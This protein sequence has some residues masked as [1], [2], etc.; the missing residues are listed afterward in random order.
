MLENI[1]LNARRAAVVACLVTTAACGGATFVLTPDAAVPFAKGEV[2]AAA[3]DNGNMEYTVSVEHLGDPAKLQPS[4][5]TYVVW[6]LPKKDD[7]TLQNM[8][9][10]KVDSSYNGE[11]TFKAAF[12]SF[13]LTVTAEES[14]DATK[15][16]GRDILKTTVSVE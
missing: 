4:A 10:L 2:A 1:L 8:G 14:A 16:T 11:L 15:P 5:T 13:D 12:K 3:G 9:A 6:V 7:S